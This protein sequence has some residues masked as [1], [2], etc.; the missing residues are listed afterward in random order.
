MR[1]LPSASQSVDLQNVEVV[2]G[3]LTPETACRLL[4]PVLVV[5]SY[6]ISN[7]MKRWD[8]RFCDLLKPGGLLVYGRLQSP[9]TSNR[10]PASNQ[11]HEIDPNLGTR[12]ADA[13][14]L[15]HIE[16]ATIRSENG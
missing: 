6:L 15:P 2:K 9:C 13:N 10:T 7:S 14:W 16:V 4:C 1:W 8:R 11:G 5:N 3:E 12:R